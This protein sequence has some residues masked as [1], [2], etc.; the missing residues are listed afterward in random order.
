MLRSVS[1]SNDSFEYQGK[2]GRASRISSPDIV[3]LLTSM[4][5]MN[6]CTAAWPTIQ[7]WGYFFESHQSFGALWERS[8]LSWKWKVLEMKRLEYDEGRLRNGCVHV[9]E[10]RNI[11]TSNDFWLCFS[12]A[13]KSSSEAATHFPSLLHHCLHKYINLLTHW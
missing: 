2:Q 10:K 5:G 7:A 4:I 12:F 9:K 3:F 1:L 11:L 8:L 13:A 6:S